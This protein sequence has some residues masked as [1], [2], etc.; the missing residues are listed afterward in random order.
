[1]NKAASTMTAAATKAADE[2]VNTSAK[3]AEAVMAKTTASKT[4]P[5]A[6]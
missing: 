6:K 4:T 5:A 2:A 3:A 1:M